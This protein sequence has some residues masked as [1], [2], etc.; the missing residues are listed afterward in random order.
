MSSCQVTSQG[1]PIQE[2][3]RAFFKT[4]NAHLIY[5]IEQEK[6]SIIR[7]RVG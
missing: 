3:L 1:R 7:V 4:K 2:L 5:N 6:E